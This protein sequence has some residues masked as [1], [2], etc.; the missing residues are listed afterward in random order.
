VSDP[1]PH[2]FSVT[3]ISGLLSDL[4]RRLKGTGDRGS[5]FVVG[6]AAVAIVADQFMRRTLD[7]DVVTR[8]EPVLREARAIA[9][10]R[11]LPEDWLNSRAS[12]WMPPIP[13][14][15]LVPPAEPGL[16]VTY[17]SDEF[18]LATKLVAQRR[19]DAGDIKVLAKHLSLVKPSADALE[20]VIR[21]YY[22]DRSKLEFII[23]GPDTDGEIRLL[24]ERAS[25]LL[26]REPD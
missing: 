18:L 15:V 9:L 10:E 6:G 21:K 4:D 25:K 26:G 2:Q 17:A 16:R 8:D 24:A 1:D 23:D 12:M 7:V 3:E 11:G 20:T 13:P 14:E 5:V 19:T 22:T